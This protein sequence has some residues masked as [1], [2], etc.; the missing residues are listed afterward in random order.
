MK[1]D[2]FIDSFWSNYQEYV[3]NR[4]P[5]RS[6]VLSDHIHKLL[7]QSGSFSVLSGGCSGKEMC[8]ADSIGTPSHLGVVIITDTNPFGA[9]SDAHITQYL[10]RM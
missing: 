9:F 10:E 5:S 7:S 8:C 4:D 1:E 3:V 2:L 6:G